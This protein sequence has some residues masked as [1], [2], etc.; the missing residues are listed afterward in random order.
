MD[1]L[2]AECPYEVEPPRET[3]PP[4]IPIRRHVDLAEFLKVNNRAH[5][6]MLH[7]ADRAWFE[8]ANYLFRPASDAND[9]FLMILAQGKDP[10]FIQRAGSTDYFFDM[11]DA[12]FDSRFIF[13]DLPRG[14]LHFGEY[15]DNQVGHI[16]FLTEPKDAADVLFQVNETS[17]AC[18]WLRNDPNVKYFRHDD[19]NFNLVVVLPVGS[20]LDLDHEFVVTH[21]TTPGED[22]TF[23]TRLFQEKLRHAINPRLE[24]PSYVRPLTEAEEISKA[25]RSKY[26]ERLSALSEKFYEICRIRDVGALSPFDDPVSVYYDGH[27]YYFNDADLS[28]LEV[29]VDTRYDFY[30]KLENRIDFVAS[31]IGNGLK[32]ALEEFNVQF[33]LR[34]D[35]DCRLASFSSDV[36]KLTVYKEGFH[37]PIHEHSVDLDEFNAPSEGGIAESFVEEAK[38]FFDKYREKFHAFKNLYEANVSYRSFVNQSAR[39]PKLDYTYI[40]RDF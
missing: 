25:D 11:E 10:Y 20:R 14:S 21:P 6:G 2:A 36:A 16:F 3:D 27:T 24:E 15:H 28:R 37:V 32:D 9:T 29:V 26:I 17:G 34:V 39:E 19:Q 38:Q 13:P 4:E 22:R 5:C 35:R 18:E 31:L 40:F 30:K 12:N 7:Y 8:D 1:R 33:T 23:F